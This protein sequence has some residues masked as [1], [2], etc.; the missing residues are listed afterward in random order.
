MVSGEPE[1]DFPAASAFRRSGGIFPCGCAQCDDEDFFNG[2]SSTG[3][4]GLYGFDACA[5]AG[6]GTAALELSL[7]HILEASFFCPHGHVYAFEKNPEAIR[8]MEENRKK[9]G[10]GNITIIE[11]TAPESFSCLENPALSGAKKVTHAFLGCLLYT[12]VIAV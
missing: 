11:G 8:L 7:I 4:S 12:S 10:Q 5:K 1:G 2:R 6:R 3:V 9:A